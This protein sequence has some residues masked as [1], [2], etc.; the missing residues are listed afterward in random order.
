MIYEVRAD[1]FFE[2]EDEAV[3]FAHDCEVA[4]AKAVV[5][6]PGQEN[7]QCS[8]YDYLECR[9]DQHPLEPCSIITHEDNC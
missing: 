4:L 2:K 9:H 8:G 7:Q 1:L 5:V 3:D 6:N